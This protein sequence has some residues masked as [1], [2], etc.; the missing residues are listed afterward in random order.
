MSEQNCGACGC[1]D[2][3]V[4]KNKS[5]GVSEQQMCESAD[6]ASGKMCMLPPYV[7]CGCDR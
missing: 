3:S 1:Y 5:L 2:R 4:S 7:T 6:I